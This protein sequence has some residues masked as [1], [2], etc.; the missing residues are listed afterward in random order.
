MKLILENWRT[1]CEEDFV[2]LYESY[3]K[4]TI[5]EE[6]LLMLWEGNVN[7]EYEQML[8]EGIMDILA[9]GY[10][11]G[12]QLVGKAKEVYDNAVAKV[13]DFYIKLLNQAWLLTQKVKQGLQKV[14]SVLRSVYDKVSVFCDKHPIFCQVVKIFLAMLAITAVMVLFSNGAEAAIRSPIN[15]RVVND[16][17]VDA[18]KGMLLDAAQD[19]PMANQEVQE[20]FVEAYRWLEKAHAS[21]NVVDLAQSN[22]AGA[23]LVV[24]MFDNLKLVNEDPTLSDFIKDNWY[25]EM[26][27]KGREVVETTTQVTREVYE[28]GKGHETTYIEF[29][30]LAGPR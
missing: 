7:R 25:V 21:K 10:E 30:S 13:G 29:T 6:R 3:E 19:A 26:V 4:G 24:K 23:K 5:T 27:L 15:G 22:E 16:V 17:G 11:K 12:K 2:M 18:I 20:S 14:A 28:T 1:Y 9:I 8:N